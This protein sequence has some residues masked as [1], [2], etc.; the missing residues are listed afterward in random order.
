MILC[1]KRHNASLTLRVDNGNFKERGSL[2]IRS[3]EGE[4]ELI[5]VVCGVPNMGDRTS[6]LKMRFYRYRTEV[7]MITGRRVSLASESKRAR[8]F[9]FKFK[10]AYAQ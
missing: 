6:S 10:E 1:D 3:L 9:K 8:S 2:F 7:I 4:K 5:R